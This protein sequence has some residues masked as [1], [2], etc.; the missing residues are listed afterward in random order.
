[1]PSNNLK[2]KELFK[3]L[4]SLNKEQEISNFFLSNNIKLPLVFVCSDSLR[5]ERAL[6]WILTSVDK[7]K[8]S[9][10]LTYYAN[11]L[12]SKKAIS[13]LLENLK[14]KSLF[15][16]EKIIIIK[17]AKKL[18][19]SSLE[20]ILEQ[21]LSTSLLI[22]VCKDLSVALKKVGTSVVFEDFSSSKLAKWIKK[23]FLANTEK[24][25]SEEI[26]SYLVSSFNGSLSQLSSSIEKICLTSDEVKLEEVKQI[27]SK[28]IEANSFELFNAIASKNV[29]T[30][31]KLLRAIF[32]QGMHPLAINSFLGR[33][34]RTLV[35]QSGSKELSN[36]WFARQVKFNKNKFNQQQLKNSLNIISELD[37]ALKDSGIGAEDTMS[38]AV[39]R[40]C[41]RQKKA[42][43]M[44]SR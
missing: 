10:V 14:F 26:V 23:E 28:D 25:I 16:T 32:R 12:N 11:E 5:F 36:P 20:Q 38:N 41:L 44:T 33:C 21:D 30:S 37:F 15:Q 34:Y 31:E 4:K 3:K 1:M 35:S 9:D 43:S 7:F 42:A 40:L 8:D 18:K 39:L 27:F 13:I 2:S 24:E 29:Q 6:D 19:S 17:N 22:L